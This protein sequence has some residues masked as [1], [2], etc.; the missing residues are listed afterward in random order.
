MRHPHDGI[1]EGHQYRDGRQKHELPMF[2]A[3]RG[4]GDKQGNGQQNEIAQQ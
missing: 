3:V 2:A 1:G 4:D